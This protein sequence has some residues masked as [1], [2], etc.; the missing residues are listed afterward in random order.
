MATYPHPSKPCS[1]YLACNQA[2]HYLS[3][4]QTGHKWHLAGS[5]PPLPLQG[6]LALPKVP[7]PSVGGPSR[8]MREASAC[9][10]TALQPAGVIQACRVS[11]MVGRGLAGH[12]SACPKISESPALAMSPG[13]LPQHTRKCLLDV[14]NHFSPSLQNSNIYSCSKRTTSEQQVA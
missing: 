10:P 4:T 9:R 13:Q 7:P 11:C 1:I 2:A 5:S 14:F 3:S 8:Q 12:L 6:S